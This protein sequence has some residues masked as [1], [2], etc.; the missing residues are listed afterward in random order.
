M[1]K[2]GKYC[3]KK[4]KLLVLSNFYFCRNVFEKPYAAEAS[5]STYMREGVKS[6]TMK[7]SKMVQAR[8]R[9]LPYWLKYYKAV[10]QN[11]RME[12][13]RRLVD[14]ILSDICGYRSEV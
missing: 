8:H 7:L 5:E 3:G 1:T 6:M 9:W 10:R 4:E 2:S 14:Y 13:Y 11:A 12:N